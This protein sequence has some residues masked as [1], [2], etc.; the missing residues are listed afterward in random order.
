[1]PCLECMCL[2]RV[3]KSNES[4]RLIMCV[5][6]VCVMCVCVFVFVSD[7][8]WFRMMA[9][10]GLIHPILLRPCFLKPRVTS[11]K[12]PVGKKSVTHVV[13]SPTYRRVLKR[14]TRRKLTADASV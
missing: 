4:S 3:Y 14:E 7:L 11:L 8:L 10:C 5:S 12:N 1:M 2:P 9:R 6:S 13:C